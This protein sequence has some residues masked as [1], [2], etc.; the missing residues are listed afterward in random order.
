MR[1]DIDQIVGRFI[2]KSSVPQL[3]VSGDVPRMNTEAQ[4]LLT[5]DHPTNKFLMQRLLTKLGFT[6]VDT[7]DNGQEA[8]D[9]IDEKTYDLILMDCQMPKMDGYEATAWI[10]KLEDDFDYPHVPII[11][12]TANAMV[13]DREKCIKAGMDDYISKPV[14]ANQFAKLLSHWLPASKEQITDSHTDPVENSFVSPKI[15]TINHT[16]TPINLD[17]LA[18]FTDGDPDV[19]AELFKLFIGQAEI[20]MKRFEKSHTTNNNDEWR[21]TAHKFKGAAANLG[22]EKLSGLCS[23]AEMHFEEGKENKQEY[24][25]AIK[26][27]YKELE[28]YMK[29]SITS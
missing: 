16:K 20:A 19:E 18:M 8:L 22:A 1:D 13:G 12:M 24:L 3:R 9:A 14:D 2:N 10:R 26:L 11:A 27:A 7:A 23:I 21:A 28:N 15:N 25:N 17:H 5:E 4:I 29:G 6:H